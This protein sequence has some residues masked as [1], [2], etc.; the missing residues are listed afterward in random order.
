MPQSFTGF[1]WLEAEADQPVPAAARIEEGRLVITSGDLEIIDWSL[2][3]TSV[4]PIP[5]GF[6]L[7][8][9]DEELRFSTRQSGFHQALASQRS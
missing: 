3:E 2:D 7:R 8:S 5:N 6:M 1:I 4:A 9:G